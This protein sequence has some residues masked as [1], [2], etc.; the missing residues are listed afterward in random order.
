[1]TGEYIDEATTSDHSCSCDLVS[2]MS[3]LAANSILVDQ[4]FSLQKL[5]HPKPSSGDYTDLNSHTNLSFLSTLTNHRPPVE[6][7]PHSTLEYLDELSAATQT[8]GPSPAN[9]KDNTYIQSTSETG[10]YTDLSA[11]GKFISSSEQILS[12]SSVN[13]TSSTFFPSS[14]HVCRPTSTI[15]EYLTDYL[16]TAEQISTEQINT[17]NGTKSLDIFNSS[18]EDKALQVNKN[19]YVEESEI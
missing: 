16:S 13:N 14:Q 19:G 17:T 12:H 4:S 9:D 2:D 18:I 1:M 10:E 5:P 8:V 6:Q 7:C 3:A 15:G 11:S